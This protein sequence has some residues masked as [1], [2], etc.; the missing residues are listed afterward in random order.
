ME[1]SPVGRPAW[2]ERPGPWLA[3]A[4]GLRLCV[5][6]AV[7]L[8]GRHLHPEDVTGYLCGLLLGPDGQAYD[9]A[10]R[11]VAGLLAGEAAVF[12]PVLIERFLNYPII[13]GT[14]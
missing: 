10:A 6:G 12:A 14:L 4:L 2:W 7:Y 8:L 3:L 9:T 1:A 13:L 5:A 11:Q